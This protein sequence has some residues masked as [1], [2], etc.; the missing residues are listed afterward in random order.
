MLYFHSWSG[1]K[2]S[3]ASIILDHIHG[4]PHSEIVM[5]EVMFD[6]SRN[7]S[8]ELPEHMDF[9]YNKAK[10]LFEEWGYKVTVLRGEVDYLKSFHHILQGAKAKDR[11][12]KK[13]GFPLGGMCT[14][15]RDCKT[16]VIKNFYRQFDGQEITQYVGIA[17]D[18][19]KRLE[20]LRGTNK[21]SLLERYGYT[22]EM[23]YDLCKEYDLLSPIYEFSGRGGCWFCPNARYSELARIRRKHPHLW[24]ELEKLSR[25][26]NLVSHGFKY[27][28]T[29]QDVKI[30]TG[31]ILA[32]WEIAENQISIF[33][34]FQEV[35]E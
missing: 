33:D 15:N 10:P 14:I 28:E 18:E 20:R 35:E 19:P 17:I 9:V 22:E 23:A 34:L 12:G 2:D 5:A 30:K 7:I 26:K 13:R 3:T 27:G 4:L 16:G 8:G 6:N 11:I 1:G 32:E 29:V 31:A 24:D 25:E 21:I